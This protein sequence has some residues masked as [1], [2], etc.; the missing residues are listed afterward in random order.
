MIA[1][2]SQSISGATPVAAKM[3][4]DDIPVSLRWME[5]RLP[6]IVSEEARKPTCK[7][8]AQLRAM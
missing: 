8:F 7:I 1:L 3:A 4:D 6:R 5:V 2:K